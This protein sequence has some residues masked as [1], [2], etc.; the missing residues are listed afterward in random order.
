LAA[1]VFVAFD[2]FVALDRPAAILIEWPQRDPRDGRFIFR[3][4]GERRT[5]PRRELAIL[6]GGR[7]DER[8]G[9]S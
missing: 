4:V 8:P 6:I 3:L 5:I 7:S 1:L 9:L 2:D